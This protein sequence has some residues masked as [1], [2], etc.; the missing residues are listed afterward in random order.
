[1]AKLFGSANFGA[2]LSLAGTFQQMTAVISPTMFSE[3]W[4]NFDESFTLNSIMDSCLPNGEVAFHF[5]HP[6]GIS[7]LIV[8][9]FA[10]VGLL[11]AITVGPLRT[12]E[13]RDHDE[14][15]S[16]A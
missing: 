10:L 2:A 11:F 9:A 5:D 7:F 13:T 3:I 16:H 8:S 12:D 15:D 4:S 1:M 14:D 6:F